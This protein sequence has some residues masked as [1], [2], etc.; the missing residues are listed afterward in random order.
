MNRDIVFVSHIIDAINNINNST[1]KLSEDEFKISEDIK[2]ACIRRL[3][4]IGEAVKNI[5]QETKEGYKEVEWRKVAGT[6]DR[7]IHAYFRVNLNTVW[8][9]I[10]KDLPILKKQIEKIKKELIDEG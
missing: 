5:S 6:R 9:I 10:K 8:E 3:E 7:V 4:I 2:D 1:N